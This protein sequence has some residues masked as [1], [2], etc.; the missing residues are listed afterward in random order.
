VWAAAVE[1]MID[2]SAGACACACACA[3]AGEDTS[4]ED[5]KDEGGPTHNDDDD[6]G[7][8]LV[9]ADIRV[10]DMSVTHYVMSV[11]KQKQIGAQ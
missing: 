8:A 9:E 4:N 1:R 11:W 6:A 3:C 7:A 10:A 2:G 5:A